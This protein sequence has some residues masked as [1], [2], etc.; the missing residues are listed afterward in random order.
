MESRVKILMLSISLMLLNYE[1]SGANTLVEKFEN[2]PQSRWVFFA[3]TVMG[4]K[5]EGKLVFGSS[6]SKKFARLSGNVSVENNGG[7]IQMRSNISGVD[8]N[9]K[10]I[11]VK[12]RGNGEQYYIFLRTSGTILP[13]QYYKASFPTTG[14]WTEVKIDFSNFQKSGVFLSK[15]I[16][17][18][19]IKSVGIVAFGKQ[20][21][22]QVDI[23]ELNFY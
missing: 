15:K 14:N 9:G 20:F 5:S 12:V 19:S 17:P 18:N 11:R 10:G 22:A 2:S 23:C 6:G 21:E 16:N 1:T 7:F 4:G 8:E 13:W 3:D